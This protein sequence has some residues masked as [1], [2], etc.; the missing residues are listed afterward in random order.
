[1]DE[2]YEILIKAREIMWR[3][4][5]KKRVELLFKPKNLVLVK[6][7]FMGRFRG[8]LDEINKGPYKFDSYDSKNV[9]HI[10]TPRGLP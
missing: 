4:A 3:Y 1:M 6:A 10:R 9:G 2:T 8:K 5:N 7:E